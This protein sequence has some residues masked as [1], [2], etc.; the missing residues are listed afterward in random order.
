[1]KNLSLIIAVIF[2]V[3]MSC[4]STKSTATQAEIDALTALVKEKKFKIESN[5]AYPQ[6]SAAMQSVLNSGI[7][8]PGSSAGSIN[9]V[10]NTNFLTISGDSISSYLPYFGERHM[11]VAYGCTD[12]GIEFKGLT[13]NY[14]SEIN[15]DNSYTITFL[16]KSNS[17]NFNVTIKL[18]PNLKSNMYLSSASRN[19]ISYSGEVEHI[20]KK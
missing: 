20:A 3:G 17:E 15:K 2:M 13:E 18:F 4:S 9:L 14:K 6:S 7:M 1:M 10:G 11:N 5:W 19:A 16:A 12:A 8:Q